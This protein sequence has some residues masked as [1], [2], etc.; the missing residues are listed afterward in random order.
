MVFYVQMRYIGFAYIASVLLSTICPTQLTAAM[1]TPASVQHMEMVEI[2]MT[3]V[4]PMTLA[5]PVAII[6]VS[7]TMPMPFPGNCQT[8]LCMGN[9]ANQQLAPLVTVTVQL[10]RSAAPPAALSPTLLSSLASPTPPDI[11]SVFL[12]QTITPIVLRV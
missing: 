11:G 3:P 6:S 5:R 7:H 12:A 10:P 8:G 9:H 1:P 4:V 2:A